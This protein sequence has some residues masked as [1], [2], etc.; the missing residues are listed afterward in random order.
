MERINFQFPAAN[1]AR[2]SA[3]A[4]VVGSGDL[5]L[6]ETALLDALTNIEKDLS[7]D[8]AGRLDAARRAMSKRVRERLRAVWQED[9][10]PG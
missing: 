7:R 6:V 2:R 10:Q 1:S 5:D 8:L 9:R 3:L 4:G